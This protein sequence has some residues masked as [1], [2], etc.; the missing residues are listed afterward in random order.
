MRVLI[1]ISQ[2]GEMKTEMDKK[3][4]SILNENPQVPESRR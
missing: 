1:K 2:I 4:S 3:Y